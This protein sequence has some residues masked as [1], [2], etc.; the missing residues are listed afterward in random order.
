MNKAREWYRSGRRWLVR[1]TRRPQVGR[2]D[3]GDLARL[4]PISRDW[5]F[6]RGRPVDRFY[7]EQFL[8]EHSTDIRGRVL[9]VS[10]ND[11]TV[12]FGGDRVARSDVL[13]V[14]E[15]NP[16]ATVIA[17]LTARE[18]GLEG[19]FDCIVCT[20]TLQ[21]IY[22]VRAAVAQLHRWLKP[23]GVALVTVPGIAQISRED[24]HRTGD[25]W[26]F[27]SAS[28]ERM[29]AEE[30]GDQAA[31]VTACGNVLASVALLEGIAAEEIE[32]ADLLESDPQFQL[33]LTVRAVRVDS[34]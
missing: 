2:V 3:F 31:R 33:L 15:G 5:G 6:D 26:R 32:A 34:P 29:F 25:Y 14:M 8:S 11:Y 9:E 23:G 17:D 22:D 18:P 1:A 21:F 27:T 10:N 13:D 24:M 4:T 30:F 20:Q 16:R 12:R 28:L 7:I 19:V